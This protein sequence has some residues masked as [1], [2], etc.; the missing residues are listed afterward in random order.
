MRHGKRNGLILTGVWA[1]C[2]LIAGCG[3]A[4]TA[5]KS[6]SEFSSK[7]GA[8]TCKYP[9]GWEV[10]GGGGT[11]GEYSQTKF[12]KGPAEIRIEADLAGSL[13][14]GPSQ[15]DDAP[16]G[17]D[18][19]PVA[20]V[21]EMKQKSMKDEFNDYK[22]RDPKPFMSKGT[23]EGRK[24]IFTAAGSFGGKIYGYRATLL[25]NDKRLTIVCQ[26]PARDWR[27][28]RKAFDTVI[29]SIGR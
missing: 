5:P 7:D 25:T 2:W 17:S 4:V 13:M 8:F 27:T 12:I 18:M 22:E 29:A 24:S 20:R 9:A 28:L 26:C 3:E 23:G 19:K 11:R 14:A 21:H 15:A 16:Y 10:E 6:Y 1:G